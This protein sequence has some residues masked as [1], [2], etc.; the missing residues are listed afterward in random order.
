MR[1]TYEY[2]RSGNSL[3]AYN[4]IIMS[5]T[6]VDICA[7]PSVGLPSNLIVLVFAWPGPKPAYSVCQNQQP[8]YSV[9]MQSSRLVQRQRKNANR[10]PSYGRRMHYVFDLSVHMLCLSFSFVFV[11]CLGAAIHMRIKMY[12]HGNAGLRQVRNVSDNAAVASRGSCLCTWKWQCSA[13]V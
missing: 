13:V 2:D 6:V 3:S 5:Y 9:Y 4:V 7:N 8:K 10:H 11:S 1:R 12:V